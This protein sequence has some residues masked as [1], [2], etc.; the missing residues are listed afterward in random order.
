[1]PPA[2]LERAAHP[3]ERRTRREHTEGVQSGDNAWLIPLIG[4]S[5]LA[6]ALGAALLLVLLRGRRR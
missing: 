6:L 1:M 4:G 5:V 2:H 3:R